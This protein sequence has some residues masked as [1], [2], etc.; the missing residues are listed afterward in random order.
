MKKHVLVPTRT[1]QEGAT[2]ESVEGAVG[3]KDML[4]DD[5]R[6]LTVSGMGGLVE[7]F[8]NQALASVYLHREHAIEVAEALL[9]ET[10][11]TVDRKDLHAAA[12][13]VRDYAGD[14]T[15]TQELV[16]RLFEAAKKER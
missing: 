12:A 11:V 13:L 6:R 9:L 8:P 10:M 16:R 5:V 4:F 14:D 2:V 3:I 15:Q 7:G 1:G